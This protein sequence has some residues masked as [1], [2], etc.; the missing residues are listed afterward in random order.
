LSSA[1]KLGTYA[2]VAVIAGFELV[3]FWLMLHPTAPPDFRAYY[4]DK[5]T[6]CLNQPVEGTYA[7]GTTLDLSGDRKITDPVR[8]CGWEG[9]SGEGFHAVGTSSRLRFVYA[10]PANGLT[11]HLRMVAERHD[12][13]PSQRVEVKANGQTVANLLVRSS[14]PEAFAIRLPADLVVAAAGRIELELDYPDAIK[15][16]VNDPDTRYR[17]IKLASVA[18]VPAT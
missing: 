12:S 8:V 9:P 5:S 4:I 18:L 16:G 6:T 2:L 7:L 1:L 13:Q 14:A 15:M 11:L 17:S 10:E 3:V